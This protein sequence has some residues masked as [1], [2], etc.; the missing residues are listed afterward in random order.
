MLLAEKANPF[1]HLTR[2]PA[3]GLEPHFQARVFALE[4]FDSLGACPR[5]ARRALKRFHSRLCLQRS[6]PESSKLIA[7]VMNQGLEVRECG[8][9]FRQFVV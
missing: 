4:L 8:L 5:C 2:S 9:R 3:R 6:P 1:Q 7:E